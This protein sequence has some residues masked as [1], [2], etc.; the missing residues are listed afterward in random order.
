MKYNTSSEAEASIRVEGFRRVHPSNREY[1]STALTSSPTQIKSVRIMSVKKT[2]TNRKGKV[3]R[4][5][6]IRENYK[7][8]RLIEVSTDVS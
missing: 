3:V 2:E 1:R 4:K 8:V 7:Y 5:E 6:V